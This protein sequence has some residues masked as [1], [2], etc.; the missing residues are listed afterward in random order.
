[1]VKL[2]AMKFPG[3]S[4]AYRTARN[5]LLIEEVKLRRHLEA[6]AALRCKLPPG[7][8]LKE[9]YV[10]EE[11]APD[12][13]DQAAVKQVRFSELFEKDK[14]SLIIYSFMYAPEANTPCPMCTALLDSLNGAAF[15]ARDR[16]NLVVVAKAPLQKIRKWAQRR[17]WSNLRLLSS[18]NNTYNADYFG[19]SVN[20]GQTPAINVF[21]KKGRSIHHFWN[22]ELFFV[23]SEKGQD[24]RGAD[25][26][27]PLWNLFDLT[28]EGRGKDWYPKYSY[29]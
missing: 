9:N 10:F 19:E 27:W 26:I 20:G 6:V 17:G 2:H 13:A 5:K 28:P 25:L 14:N 16:I 21:R 24:P 1:M 15:H 12:F 23:A 22:S 3:E 4:T 7:G 18:L 11:G 8:K 29:D